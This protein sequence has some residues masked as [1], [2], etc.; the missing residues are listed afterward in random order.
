VKTKAGA[1]SA[2]R[3]GVVALVLVIS[4]TIT[5]AS[6]EDEV[7]AYQPA[8]ADLDG[9]TFQVIPFIWL[10]EIEGTV[11]TRGRTAAIDV[12]FSD[13]FDLMGDGDLF[14]SGGHVEAKYRDLSLFLDA[15]GGMARPTSQVTFGRDRTF[16]GKADVTMNFVFFEFGPAYR[17][18]DWPRGDGGR[19]IQIDLLTGGRFMY[20]YESI[21]AKGSQGRFRRYAN[22]TSSW[23]DPFVG[24]RFTVPI[25]DG[26]DVLFRGDIGG[27]GAG[28][29]LAW[30]LLGGLAYQLPWHPGAATTSIYAIY[31]A[32]DFDY[33]HGS[34][35]G[36][37]QAALDL[38]GPAVGLAFNF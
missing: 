23:V 20:F 7:S 33:E 1:G 29:Q 30:N 6:A 8:R 21:T 10:P 17:V 12:D 5:R 11:G 4:C 28:S 36:A 19:P 37:T 15:F 14:A 3:A 24:G 38:R 31:K 16:S 13:L 18:L 34:G 27:F 25:A 32:L 9:W 2:L 26:L 35:A 22:A